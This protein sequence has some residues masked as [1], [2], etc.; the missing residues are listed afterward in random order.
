MVSTPVVAG[1]Q[2]ESAETK[3]DQKSVTKVQMDLMPPERKPDRVRCP[4]YSF[5]KNRYCFPVTR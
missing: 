2:W 1:N 4:N 3:T 5:I